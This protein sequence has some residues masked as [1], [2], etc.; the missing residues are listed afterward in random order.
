VLTA[1]KGESGVHEER[2]DKY[3]C[4][5]QIRNGIGKYE[6]VVFEQ[7]KL[8]NIV[9]KNKTVLA[10]TKRTRSKKQLT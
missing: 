1:C 3:I 2:V 8:V 9:S 4:R 6:L 10:R 7:G 5:D